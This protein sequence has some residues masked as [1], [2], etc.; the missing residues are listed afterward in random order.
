MQDRTTWMKGKGTPSH[1][2][3]KACGPKTS[4]DIM[5]HCR[6]TAHVLNQNLTPHDRAEGRNKMRTCH[7]S[8]GKQHHF[9]QLRP[10]CLLGQQ[11]LWC[12]QHHCH[13]KSHSR[14]HLLHQSDCNS[15]H[16]S[17]IGWKHE[18]GWCHHTGYL[19]V[20]IWSKA[21]VGSS[22]VALASRHPSCDIFWYLWLC[23]PK[24]PLTRSTASSTA[25]KKVF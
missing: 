10:S 25:Q 8:L 21:W 14:H 12:H 7:S 23:K 5:L 11:Q 2:S 16:C 15:A 6:M 13:Y 1:Q 19:A 3:C 17:Q 20:K 24:A 9:A 4:T 18:V 22:K